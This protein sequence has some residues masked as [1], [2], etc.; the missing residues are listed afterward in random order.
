MHP[1]HEVNSQRKEL[2]LMTFVNWPPNPSRFYMLKVMGLLS[3][4][5]LDATLKKKMSD[6]SVQREGC[7]PA[8]KNIGVQSEAK[9]SFKLK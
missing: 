4:P 1:K 7:S 8:P 5:F 3:S 6:A 9:S 2:L